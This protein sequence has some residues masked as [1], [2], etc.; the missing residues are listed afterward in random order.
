V[1]FETTDVWEH[2]IYGYL[3]LQYFSPL[4]ELAQ[5]IL[6]H[7]AECDEIVHL[8]NPVHQVL[9]Q[10]ISLCDRADVFVLHNGS[11]DDFR[12]Y[13]EKNRNIKYRGDIVDMFLASGV[14]I[15]NVFDEMDSDE[16]FGHVLYDTPMTGEDV[17]KY[18][19]MIVFSID[20]RSYQTVIHTVTSTCV[21]G[22]LARLSGADEDEIENIKTGAM[23]HDIGKIGI[24]VHIL[25][26]PGKLNDD[27][28]EIMRTHVS[29]TDK[30]LD[31]N[32]PDA[33]RH[34]AV[35]HHE[36]LDGSGYPRKLMGHDIVFFERIVAISDILSALRAARSYKEAY[37]KE[38]T[39]EILGDMGA[40]KLLDPDIV[41]LAIGHFDE[42]AE[43]VE[44]ESQ[45]VIG[46]YIAMNEEYLRKREE[47]KRKFKT[48][49]F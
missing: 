5:V 22:F 10:L 6:F 26:N 41:K 35:R 32:V 2:S 45:P 47:I 44:R 23:L 43:A 1:V 25:E 38:K 27:D 13:I 48:H 39:V 18:V 24:P 46:A 14:N 9:S 15:E 4:R 7:H 30:I 11:A 8:K 42:I 17:I 29:I 49:K 12:N 36:R 20:F 34:I 40:R 21:A 31:G 19:K 37:P 33:V 3:F 28:M 16:A